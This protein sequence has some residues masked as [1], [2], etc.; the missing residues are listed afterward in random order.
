MSLRR[1]LVAVTSSALAASVLLTGCGVADTDF[2]P[3]EAA[4]IEGEAISMDE[5][6]EVAGAMCDVL[7]SDARFEGQAYAGSVLRDA[8]HQGLA[9][10]VIGAELLAAYD[11][12]LPADAND[13][14][15]AIRETYAAADEDALETA[16]PAFTGNTELYNVLLALGRDELGATAD[17]Q[18]ALTAG[19][20]RAQEW[21]ESAEVETNPALPSLEIG[22]DRII[23]TRDDLSVAVSEQARSAAASSAEEPAPAEDLPASQRCS[24]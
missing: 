5:V 7:R 23:G 13:G 12:S 10:Q 22:D 20:A 2:H 19:V 3:G 1:P 24:A 15:S 8:A 14:E 17:D 6:D 16:M 4:V 18:E 9:L 11:V 21:Q